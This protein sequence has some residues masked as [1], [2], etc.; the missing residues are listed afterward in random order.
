MQ[1]L[2]LS[3]AVLPA[4]KLWVATVYHKSFTEPSA[5]P[6]YKY[7]KTNSTYVSIC[8]STSA[9]GC[10]SVKAQ[11][12]TVQPQKFDI[13]L[14]NCYKCTE[15][16]LILSLRTESTTCK[17]Y[18]KTQNWLLYRISHF[19]PFKYSDLHMCAYIY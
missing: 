4:W 17:R 2:W 8:S 11:H 13:N 9:P 7:A 14:T 3:P 10:A 6:W 15:L 18:D 16:Y 5:V 12:S 19:F 1:D